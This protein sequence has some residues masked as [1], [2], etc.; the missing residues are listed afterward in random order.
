MIKHSNSIKLLVICVTPVY[1]SNEDVVSCV[2]ITQCPLMSQLILGLGSPS[3]A[4]LIH[5][6]IMHF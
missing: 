1:S 2:H 4:T 3:L 6:E 5:N